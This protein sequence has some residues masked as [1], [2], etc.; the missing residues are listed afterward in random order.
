[1]TL[2]LDF[3]ASPLLA[4]I[5]QSWS[6]GSTRHIWVHL[7]LHLPSDRAMWSATFMDHVSCVFVH[8]GALLQLICRFEV[9]W[10]QHLSKNPIAYTFIAHVWCAWGKHKVAFDAQ[11]IEFN[12]G[13]CTTTSPAT[14]W[15]SDLGLDCDC[16]CVDISS[17]PLAVKGCESAA[18]PLGEYQTP[19]PHGT[20]YK[21][22][23]SRNKD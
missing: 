8:G 16:G 23:H 1:M 13:S 4:L 12:F 15:T 3:F 11:Q 20:T 14:P 9:A 17:Q 18:G 5:F 2:A 7:W 10:F 22:P 6:A 21:E 19:K